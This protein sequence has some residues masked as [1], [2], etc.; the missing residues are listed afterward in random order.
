MG[1]GD[2]GSSRKRPAWVKEESKG[3][4]GL[5]YPSLGK[6]GITGLLR[7]GVQSCLKR[8]EGSWGA[9]G[10]PWNKT[11]HVPHPLPAAQNMGHGPRASLSPGNLSELQYPRGPE[12]D[13]AVHPD[14]QVVQE[15]EALASGRGPGSGEHQMT[16]GVKTK[17]LWFTFLIISFLN[18]MLCG[19]F[20]AYTVPQ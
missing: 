9:E 7:L 18:P 14:P 16:T 3:P 10:C 11:Q 12:S 1:H 2:R 6:T 5:L 4:R 13:S 15:W 19:R 20:I 8:T 17:E